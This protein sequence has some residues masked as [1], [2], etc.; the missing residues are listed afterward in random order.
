MPE[1]AQTAINQWGN[2]LA[3]RL[4]S[5]IAKAAGVSEGTQVRV[6]AELGRVVIETIT[7]RQSLEERLARYERDTYGGEVMPLPPVGR[8]VIE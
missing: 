4:N 8:E 7:R 1:V 3:V 5:R 2:G 6:R